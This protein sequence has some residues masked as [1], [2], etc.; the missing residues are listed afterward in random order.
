MKKF[1]ILFAVSVLGAGALVPCMALENNEVEKR[2]TKEEK[3]VEMNLVS[4][5]PVS[6]IEQPV[7]FELEEGIESTYISHWAFPVHT[8]DV[9]DSYVP[10]IFRT[11]KS[12]SIE[13]LKVII[14]VNEKGKLSGY[15]VLNEGVDKGLVERIGH[16]VRQMPNAL[17]VPGFQNYEAMEFELVIR[18]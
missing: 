14:S 13:E 4:L 6:Q 18:K 1:F 10:F 17:P 12:A 8:L 7:Y 11:K 2:V 3:R 16:V 5:T 15:E 9:V